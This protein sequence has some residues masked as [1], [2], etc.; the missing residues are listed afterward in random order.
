[1]IQVKYLKSYQSYIIDDEADYA[2]QN[3][4]P[5]GDGPTIH[6]DLQKL[7]KAVS[8][9]CYLAYTATPQACLSADPNDPIGYPKDFWWHL[10][11][12]LVKEGENWRPVSYLGSWQVFWEYNEYLLHRMGR[13]E[14]HHIEKD[15]MG[16]SRGVWVPPINDNYIGHFDNG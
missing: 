12:Y 15:S 13:D 8:H 9:N 1:M 3:T 4:D 16:R 5:T 14:W 2:S 6:N 10:E 11:P 7:R